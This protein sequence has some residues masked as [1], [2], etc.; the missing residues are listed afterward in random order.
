MAIGRNI[1]STK[2]EKESE[3]DMTIIEDFLAENGMRI[4]NVT[5]VQRQRVNH[6]GGRCP[7]NGPGLLKRDGACDLCE[8]LFVNTVLELWN[9]AECEGQGR[10]TGGRQ[11]GDRAATRDFTLA[12]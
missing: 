5:R 11:Q 1:E 12:A 2:C 7:S 3:T 8:T 4:W 6:S 10:G 9:K